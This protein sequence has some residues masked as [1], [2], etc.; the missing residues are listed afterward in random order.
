ALMAFPGVAEAAVVG[1][2]DPEWG[3]RVVAA[4]TVREP[5]DLRALDQFTRDRLAGAKR[6]KTIRVLPEL[7]RN[8]GGK[9]D[10][11]A[12]RRLLADGGGN[13]AGS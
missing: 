13:A 2:P 3:E 5:I 10:T 12:L 7:P 1:V 8:S 4:V 11:A 6:P 9:V